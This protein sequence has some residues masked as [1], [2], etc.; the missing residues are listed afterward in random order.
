MKKVF[1]VL[2]ALSLVALVNSVFAAETIVT[3]TK[4]WKSVPITVDTNGNTYTVTNASDV[5]T[6]G[7]YYYSYSGY[8]CFREKQT[9]VTDGTP[10]TYT[11]SGGPDIYCYAE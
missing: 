7:D 10:V 9:Y 5:P 1:Y 4:E 8:R 2:F 3:H 6:S 11:V